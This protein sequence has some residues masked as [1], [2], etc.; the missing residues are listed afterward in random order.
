MTFSFPNL[1]ND[2]YNDRL[3]EIPSKEELEFMFHT[4]QK[5]QSL[6]L[7]YWHVELWL[8][9]YDIIEETLLR[10]VDHSRRLRKML[11]SFN[12][13]FIALIQNFDNLSCFEKFL[14]VSLFNCIYKIVEKIIAM[15]VKSLLLTPISNE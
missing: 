1:V 8:G 12:T 4:F 10:V 3:L 15:R 11:A 5:D 14:L 9:F 7:D 13:K 2:E 6:R